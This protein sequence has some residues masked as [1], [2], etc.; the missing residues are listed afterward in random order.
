MIKW[1]ILT[2]IVVCILCARAEIDIR[3]PSLSNE[4]IQELDLKFKEVIS[5][6]YNQL[7]PQ[8]QIK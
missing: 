2:L 3:N 8:N 5:G 7:D 4:S 6:E 1:T